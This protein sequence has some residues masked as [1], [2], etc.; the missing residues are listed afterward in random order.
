MKSNLFICL[1]ISMATHVT[2]AQVV[3]NNFAIEDGEVIW[4]KVFQTVL[5]FEQLTEKVRDSGLFEKTELGDNKLTG[6]LRNID[7]DFKGA[8]FSE[9]GT[10][11]YIARSHFSAFAVIE[12]KDGKYRVTLKRIVLTQKYDDGVSKQGEQSSLDTYALKTAMG[13]MKPAFKK[14]PSLILDHTFTTEFSFQDEAI[15]NDW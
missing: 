13:E 2:E 7:A 5:T 8:G 15:K 11:I 1:V 10:P 14:S 4:R 3:I 9:M 12:F 6:V